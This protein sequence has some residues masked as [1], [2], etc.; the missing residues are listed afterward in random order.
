MLYKFS[1]SFHNEFNVNSQQ[2]LFIN[3]VIFILIVL[4]FTLGRSKSKAPPKLNMKTGAKEPSSSASEGGAVVQNYAREVGPIV[5]AKEM[6]PKPVPPLLKKANKNSVYFI[7]NGHEWDAHEVLGLKSEGSV[8][9]ATAQYQHLIKTSD[10]SS[11]E[12]YETAYFSILKS[13]K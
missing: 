12:F 3:F 10:P 9:E 4:F 5:V 7:Y 1:T 6:L 8:S 2:L 11:F 13:K